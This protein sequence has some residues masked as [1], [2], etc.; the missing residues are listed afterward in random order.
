MLNVYFYVSFSFCGEPGLEH[1]LRLGAMR[2]CRALKGKR[3]SK[4]FKRLYNFMMLWGFS[5]KTLSGHL[6]ADRLC[7]DFTG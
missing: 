5:Y 3:F 1:G 7:A 4:G 2:R 6:D